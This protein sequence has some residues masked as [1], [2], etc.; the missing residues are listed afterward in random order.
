[1]YDLHLDRH[2][3]ID[4]IHEAIS[5]IFD[6]PPDLI[7]YVEDWEAVEETEAEAYFTLDIRKGEFPSYLCIY[8]HGEAFRQ[9]FRSEVGAAK[10]ITDR[11]SCECLISDDTRDPYNPYL[12]LLVG[13][14][15]GVYRVTVDV[16]A[17]G[18]NGEF[19][20]TEKEAYCVFR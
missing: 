16:D 13:Q 11:L 5:Y 7:V 10:A 6:I 1:M 2:V 14:D 3:P 18:N 15:G 20:I 4:Q 12:W 19:Y 17:F 8:F 9:D